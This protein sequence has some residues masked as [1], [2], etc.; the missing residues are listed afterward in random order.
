MSSGEITDYFDE[1]G[2]HQG[3]MLRAEAEQNNLVIQNVI[4]FVF[5]SLGKVW[6]QKR[7]MSKN[8]FPG[9]WDVSACGAVQSGEKPLDAAGREQEEEMGFSSELHFVETFMNK[10][11]GHDGRP[12]MRLSHLFVGISEEI[13][14]PNE[15]VDEFIALPHEEL[16]EYVRL[17]PDEYIPSFLDEI[18]RAVIAYEELA[19]R[20]NRSD[21]HE[22]GG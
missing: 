10:F 8:H 12:T 7:P 15:E 2:N 19:L 9:L 17:K 3:S 4:V 1:D 14:E 5:N 6:I 13:P 18:E 11:T 22:Y 20:A 16:V 21:T